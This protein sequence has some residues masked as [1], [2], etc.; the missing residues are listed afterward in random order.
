MNRVSSVVGII[1]VFALSGIC[2]AVALAQD[3]P[4]TN[5]EI[6]NLTKLEM[7]DAVIIA[8]IKAAKEVKFDTSTEAL[9]KLR[10]AGVSKDVIAAMI[11]RT[12]GPGPAAG[13]PVIK[14]QLQSAEGTV[15]LKPLYGLLK[16][17]SAPFSVQ[18]WL[19]FVD[20]QSKTRIRDTRPS[21]LLSL[22]RDP[23]GGWWLVRLTQYKRK[24]DIYRFFDLE[25]GGGAFSVTWSGKPEKGSIVPYEAVEE[26][27]G[28]W[29]IRPLKDLKPGEYGLF[30][31]AAQQAIT[32][33]GGGGGI[34]FDFGI[35]V[36]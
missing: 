21:I 25:G 23:R 1:L 10:E 7:G 15:D 5:A 17:Q 16:T 36:K 24:D 28:L 26:Q 12:A 22:D 18:S 2:T 20:L 19:Q 11:D 3:A 34:L 32:T 30:G 31:G 29:R 13:G 14:V 4:L 27:P 8:K 6:V 9:V 33:G 35:D